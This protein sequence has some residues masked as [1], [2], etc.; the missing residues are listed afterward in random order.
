MGLGGVGKTRAAVEYAWA[1]REDYTALILLDS[2]T[3]EKLHSSLAALATPLRLPARSAPE[4]AVRVEAALDWL[5]TNRGWLLI[6][7][8]VDT[9][10]ALTA[11]HRLLGRLTGGHVVVTSRLTGLPRGVEGLDLNVLTLEDATD[12]FCWRP[13]PTAAMPRMTWRRPGPWPRR[14]EDWPWR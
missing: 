11:A 5:N 10:P 3:P 9:E 4:E 13:P 2:E 1:H 6:L 14:S 8:N 7:D 12:F